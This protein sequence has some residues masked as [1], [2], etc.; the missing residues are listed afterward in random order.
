MK[1]F[2]IYFALASVFSMFRFASVTFAQSTT[3]FS[4]L[5]QTPV[6][7]LA[8][9]INSW[10]AQEIITGTN[11]GGYLLN[12][13]Q[14]QLGTPTGT[15]S[16]FS[17]AI[18]DRNPLD[19]TAP[20]SLLESLTGTVPAGSGVFTFQSSG[21]TLNPS[22]FYFVVA[23]AATPVASGSYKWN[24][25][26]WTQPPADSAGLFGTRATL[27]QSSDGLTWTGT[28]PNNFMFAV[29]ATAVPEPSSFVL[30]GLGG[31]F[32]FTRRARKSRSKALSQP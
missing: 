28:R 4:N 7:S 30:L 26:S 32:L 13:I 2:T 24:I 27:Y 31:S 9:G 17:L 10:C 18:Y 8:I 5:S 29:N 25:T 12:S 1:K 15:P 6:G 22:R 11:S 20:G 21:L 19:G 23:T 14:L 16:G 3:Y